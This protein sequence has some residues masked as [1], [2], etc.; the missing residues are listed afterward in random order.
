MRKT[1]TRNSNK[2]DEEPKP[3]KDEKAVKP[4][5]RVNYKPPKRKMRWEES[6][7][8]ALQVTALRQR[9]GSREM[10]SNLLYAIFVCLI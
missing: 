1:I 9:Q 10:V 2:E 3:S 6:E 5:P 4:T 7:M 8:V